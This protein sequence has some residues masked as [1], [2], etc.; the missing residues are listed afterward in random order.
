[1]FNLS[2]H[3]GHALSLF[4]M[5]FG[6]ERQSR[7]NIQYFPLGYSNMKNYSYIHLLGHVYHAVEEL[8]IQSHTR[9]PSKDNVFKGHRMFFEDD[10]L[11]L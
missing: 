11:N 8:R 2:E 6:K 9:P 3:I 5:L 10:S 7:L 4:N 1:M